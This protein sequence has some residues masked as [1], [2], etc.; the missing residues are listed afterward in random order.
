M[1]EGQSTPPVRSEP[2][3]L[4]EVLARLNFTPEQAW[5]LCADAK[6]GFPPEGCDSGVEY[7]QG[8]TLVV[9]YDDLYDV[10]NIALE[11]LRFAKKLEIKSPR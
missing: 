9:A 2:T 5:S 11:A 4:A 1:S 6:W 10:A 8:D 3:T 7:D